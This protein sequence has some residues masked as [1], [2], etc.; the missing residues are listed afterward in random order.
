MIRSVRVRKRLIW[1]TA[2][3]PVVALGTAVSVAVLSANVSEVGRG[4]GRV[5]AT[6]GACSPEP[7]LKET[8]P[9]SVVGLAS[10][11]GLP[12]STT[13]SPKVT[14]AFLVLRNPSATPEERLAALRFLTVNA[15]SAGAA[16]ALAVVDQPSSAA[17][18]E[19]ALRTL[20]TTWRE[21]ARLRSDL[22]RLLT[23]TLERATTAETALASAAALD[24]LPAGSLEVTDLS[25]AAGTASLPEARVALLRTLAS[26]CA[27]EVTSAPFERAVSEDPAPAV[28][29][30][31]L[32]LLAGRRVPEEIVR[33]RDLIV[34][35]PALRA[36]SGRA[37]A[38]VPG[39]TVDQILVEAFMAE[40]DPTVQR[41]LA[42]TITRRSVALPTVAMSESQLRALRGANPQGRQP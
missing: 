30:E 12:S 16:A 4:T 34:R 22:P 32:T 19:G 33:V 5:L 36:V 35:D 40:S 23:Q 13:E 6:R 42:A 7:R 41:T 26:A 14:E 27:P 28:R 39:E 29:A 37:L 38:S 15:P 1:L 20:A 8:G 25:R 18:L 31:A 24:A 3:V 10:R 21:A 11:E 9:S 2:F 17:L